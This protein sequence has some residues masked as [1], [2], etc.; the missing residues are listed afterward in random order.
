M[1][2]PAATTIGAARQAV[3]GEARHRREAGREPE[4]GLDEVLRV[5]GRVVARAS[6]GEQDEHRRLVGQHARE[7]IDVGTAVIDDAL[8]DLGLLEDLRGHEPAWLRGHDRSLT[9][10]LGCGQGW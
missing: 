10:A 8:E 2:A 7:G 4:L 5:Q 3:G 9:R 1:P 6:A